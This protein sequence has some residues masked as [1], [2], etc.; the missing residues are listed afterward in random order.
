MPEVWVQFPSNNLFLIAMT[1]Y[2]NWVES[3]RS[4]VISEKKIKDKND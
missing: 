2:Q 4:L 3:N 1:N